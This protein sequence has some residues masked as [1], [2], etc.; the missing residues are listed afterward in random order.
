MT[1]EACD[2]QTSQEG[3]NKQFLTQTAKSLD[4]SRQE[5][6]RKNFRQCHKLP[7]SS[8]SLSLFHLVFLGVHP[9]HMEVP[10]L[11]VESDLELPAY[12][13]AT[14]TWV[15]SHVCNLHRSSRQRRIFNPLGE[16]RD[17]T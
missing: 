17:R 16:V 4:S 3:I 8:L 10:R 9:Q 15:L 11:G 14:A 5:E 13:T 7:S 6:L 12:T 1:A 2:T